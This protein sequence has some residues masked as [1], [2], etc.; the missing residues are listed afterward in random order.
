MTLGEILDLALS[1]DPQLGVNLLD[2]MLVVANNDDPATERV[3][4]HQQRVDCLFTIF[5]L[6]HGL[7]NLFFRGQKQL[8]LHVSCHNSRVLHHLTS[9]Q[10]RLLSSNRRT[11]PANSSRSGLRHKEKMPRHAQAN[12]GK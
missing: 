5:F 8:Q 7:M 10:T 1:N 12:L 3:E 6:R 4:R 9:S 2:E 11:Q